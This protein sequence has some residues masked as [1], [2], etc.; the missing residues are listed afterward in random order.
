MAAPCDIISLRREGT[1][2]LLGLPRRHVKLLSSFTK[3]RTQQGIDMS[4]AP[5]ELTVLLTCT[6]GV[7]VS[8]YVR[9]CHSNLECTV[10]GFKYL[11]RGWLYRDVGFGEETPAVCA[12]S[13]Q[14]RLLDR[15]YLW[16]CNRREDLNRY[17][18]VV[19]TMACPW[20][21]WH[22]IKWTLSVS[23]WQNSVEL[24]NNISAFCL[25]TLAPIGYQ[26]SDI[27]SWIHTTHFYSYPCCRG[28]PCVRRQPTTVTSMRTHFYGWYGEMYW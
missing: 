17:V 10:G 9:C 15:I 5:D 28:T 12:G 11:E 7:M 3:L 14:H 19:A 4:L 16:G 21:R 26:I 8:V 24:M 23:A 18:D 22:M 6:H 20:T 2:R 13:S 27:Q 1:I 25:Q